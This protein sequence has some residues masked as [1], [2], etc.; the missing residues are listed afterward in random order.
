MDLHAAINAKAFVA[1]ATG[2]GAQVSSGSISA[3]ITT[4]I[5]TGTTTTGVRSVVFA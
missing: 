2:A 1:L 3:A 5:T 4:T